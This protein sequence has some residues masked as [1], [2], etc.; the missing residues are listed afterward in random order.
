MSEITAKIIK[1]MEEVKG[2]GKNGPWKKQEYIFETDGEYPKK[3]CIA[4]WNDK[5]SPDVLQMGGEYTVSIN[6]ESREFNDRWYTDVKM[7][8]AEKTSAQGDSNAPP[9]FTS[10]D[11]P[12]PPI[13]DDGLPF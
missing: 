3:I 4:N 7:W 6:I 11:A 10:S 13:E 1:I 2:E 12:P 9:P 8:K 5:V